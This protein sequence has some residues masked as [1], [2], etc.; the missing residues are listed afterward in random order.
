MGGGV[1]RIVDDPRRRLGS[2]HLNEQHRRIDAQTRRDPLQVV[3]RDVPLAALHPSHVRPIHLDLKRE[4]LLAE[5]SLGSQPTDVVRD[6]GAEPAGMI[7]F[8][9]PQSPNARNAGDGF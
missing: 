9:A 6:D 3:E 5:T 4:R 1:R 8:H 7:S 2:L